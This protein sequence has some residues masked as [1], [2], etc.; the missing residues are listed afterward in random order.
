MQRH[1]GRTS[2]AAS[3]GAR[4][5]PRAGTAGRR[6]CRGVARADRAGLELMP[7]VM[8][9]RRYPR[10]EPPTAPA[11]AVTGSCVPLRAP[12]S[13]PS[14]VIGPGQRHARWLVWLVLAERRAG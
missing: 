4:R 9:L 13:V 2:A 11:T 14:V 1:H 10:D 6:W 7:S 12:G 3:P 8:I 5:A